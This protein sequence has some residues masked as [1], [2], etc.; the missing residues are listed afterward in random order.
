MTITQFYGDKAAQMGL[1]TT[2]D[3]R[4]YGISADMGKTFSNKGKDLIISFTAK[5]EQ[6][7]DCGGG[8]LKIL[9]APLDQEKFGGNDKYKSVSGV[10]G[11]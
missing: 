4:F 10:K 2:Q 5:H 3:A 7:I 11:G 8:Y 9:P 1:K 6:K